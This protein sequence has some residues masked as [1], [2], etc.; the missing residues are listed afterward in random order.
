M[1]LVAGM[2]LQSIVGTAELIVV[3]IPAHDVVL[4]CAGSEMVPSGT[5][6]A[7]ADV[8][9]PDPLTACALGKRYTDHD[10]GLELL[11]VKAG[12][13]PLTVDGVQL[14]LRDAK[15]LPSSD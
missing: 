11:C 6:T 14:A 5:V 13:G 4:S 15:P 9:A 8:G 2:R 3:R 1:E 7:S 12:S 10:S